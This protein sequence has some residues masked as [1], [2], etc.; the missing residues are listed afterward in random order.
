M[1]TLSETQKRN[2]KIDRDGPK[3]KVIKG[4][5]TCSLAFLAEKAEK[6]TKLKEE[7]NRLEM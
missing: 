7:R 2:T 6:E 3:R 4:G 1:D 5:D